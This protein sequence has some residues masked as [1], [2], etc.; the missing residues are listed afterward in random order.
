MTLSRATPFAAVAALVTVPAAAEARA[1]PVDGHVVAP[2]S[3]HG[4]AVTVP[5]LLSSRSQRLLRVRSGLVWVRLPRNLRLEAPAPF[6]GGTVQIVASTLRAGDRLRGTTRLDKR[7]RRNLRR[8]ALPPVPVRR[9][10][11]S[12]R[13]SALS[14]DELTAVVLGLARQL[15]ALGVRVDDLAATVGGE[16]A[17]MR[18]DLNALSAKS[19]GMAAGLGT[20]QDSLADLHTALERHRRLFDP[21]ALRSLQA[22]LGALL[23]RVAA[24]ETQT[25]PLSTSLTSLAATAAGIQ[26][27]LTNLQGTVS[28]L[29]QE[30]NDL[31][32]RLGSAEAQLPD[33]IMQ[34]GT[35]DSTL[36][37]LDVRVAVAEDALTTLQG[38]LT[39]LT[40]W[41]D[42]LT[43]TTNGLVTT[44]GEH[45][46]GIWTLTGEVDGLT[47]AVGTLQAALGTLQGDVWGLAGSMSGLQ[48][49]V[50]RLQGTVGLICGMRI[51]TVC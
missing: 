48:S 32:T 15:A 13:A 34:I 37:A 18:D 12:K 21:T 30:V 36:Q 4:A 35:L 39:G 1:L 42:G 50:T 38:T 40:T 29:S 19:A 16:L 25:T 9:A 51:I 49:E 22:D 5:V 17:R 43:A 14:V 20:L 24:L 3:K 10:R 7:L 46:T 44:V 31:D 11:I 45:G 28:A 8:H 23:S 41:V 2:P 33:L 47:S 27:A 26:V 6:G